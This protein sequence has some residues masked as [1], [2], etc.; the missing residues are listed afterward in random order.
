MLPPYTDLLSNE[1]K[2]VFENLSAFAPAFILAGGTA[3]MLQ[4][5]HRRSY[6]FDCFTQQP[7]STRLLYKVRKNFGNDIIIVVDEEW[8]LTVRTKTGVDISFVRH[9]Y[10]SIKQP[11][12]TEYI[13][14]FHMDDL[15]ANKA[16][17]IGRRPAWR[18]Y[19]DLF[20]FLKW[21]RYSLENLILLAEKKFKGEFSPKLFLQQLVYFDDI[22]IM[23]TA[24]VKKSFT[25]E[26]IKSFLEKQVEEYLKRTLTRKIIQR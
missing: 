10:P 15:A 21:R 1:R 22:K 7:L 23:E 9:P 2:D 4:I 26:Q 20:F 11:I 19:V 17:V 5:G 18:D 13:P 16:H 8:M 12:P 14:L 3:I 24:F 25:T 6:D